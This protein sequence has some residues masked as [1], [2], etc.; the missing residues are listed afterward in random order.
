MVFFI[1]NLV[2]FQSKLATERLDI[3]KIYHPFICGPD[4]QFVHELSE[5]TGA[6]I[7]VPGHSVLKDE[8]V[9]SGDKEGVMAAK[10]AILKIYE[11]KV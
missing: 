2:L 6:H 7:R 5:Q 9:V 11:E 1:I 8:I 3:P 4:N 10:Q